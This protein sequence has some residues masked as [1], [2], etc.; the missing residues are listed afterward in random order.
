MALF[1][2]IV[3]DTGHRRYDVK[4]PVTLES[5]GQFDSATE[6]EVRAAVVRA[7]KAQHGWAAKTFD[8]RAEVLWR[9]V[10]TIV[11]RQDEIVELVMR[12]TGKARSEAVS[13]EVM[14][15]CMQISHYAKRA[16]KYL[17]TSRRRPTGVM[18]FAKKLTLIYQPLGVI[19]LITPWNGPVAL[20]ANPLA[21]ALMAGNA[22]VHKP[23]EV[24]PF[25][26]VLLKDLTVAAGLPED[27]Y[28]V[29]QGDGQ[30]GA[31]LIEAGVDKVSFTGSV[32]TGRKVGEACGRNLIPVTLELGGK[33]AMIVCRDADIDRAADGA[34]RGSFF[35]T[36]HYCCGTERVYVPESIY[37]PFVDKVVVQ[38][39][40]LRQDEAGDGDVGA[41][42]WDKQMDIIE[43]HMADAKEK[44]AKVLVGGERNRGLSG[45]FF[46]PTVVVDVDH[47]MDLMKSETF[48]PI[49]AIQKVRDEEEAIELANDSAYGLSGNVWTQD[50]DRGEALGARIR[51]GS[52]SVN[53]IAVTYGIPEAP[54]G[55]VKESGVGQVNGEVG[56]RGYC[57]LHPIIVDTTKKAQ[58]GYPYTREGAD[59]MQKLIKRVFGN[60]FLRKLFV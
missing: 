22:V 5:I 36:G 26:A 60:R 14:A 50:L 48:G 30:T 16:A 1:E 46:P 58:G 39:K 11:E 7:R 6:E 41:V 20:A 17:A 24:T 28:Q 25:S 2:A 35:N 13:M 56:I 44:G 59:G 55:G 45:Y 33:D 27:L 4:N 8:E 53:D 38:A 18:R 34:V 32:A 12:E 29:V 49:V 21:Q 10:D 57:H 43:A 40:T 52:V 3:S 9:L 51:T 42:F 19:G 23:S 15:P 54:F 31:A 37:Q 47:G